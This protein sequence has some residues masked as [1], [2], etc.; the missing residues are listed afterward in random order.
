MGE[1]MKDV[2]AGDL[3]WVRPNSWLFNIVRKFTSGEFG[4]IG[5][6]SGYCQNHILVIEAG[7]SGVDIND[8]QWRKL[9]K[10]NYS[11]YRIKGI[12][13]EIRNDLV[14]DCLERV[15]SPYDYS[16]W[17]NFLIGS[18]I[19]GKNKQLYCSEMI[20]RALRGLDLIDDVF[21]PE[22]VSPADIYRELK[23]RIVLVKKVEF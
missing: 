12:S 14:A 8:L 20:Y 10:E 2:Q 22:E 23:D 4:H 7:T 5:L 16:A 1:E 17:I 19:F 6:I 21:D 13:D 11:I 9:R 15:G 3:I 18:T